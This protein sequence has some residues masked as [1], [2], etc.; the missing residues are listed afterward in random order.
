MHKVGRRDTS[1]QA[2]FSLTSLLLVE[3]DILISQ[4]V[5][6]YA[7]YLGCRIEVADTQDA[8]KRAITGEQ[9]DIV[10]LDIHLGDS[11]GLSLVPIFKQLQVRAK[12][13][14]V[15]GDTSKERILE[16]L[17]CGAN[18]FLSKPIT[19][20]SLN[21]CLL[22][23]S[24]NFAQAGTD[25][26]DRLDVTERFKGISVAAS[27]VRQLIKQYGKSEYPVL[28]TG[29]S[30]TGKEIVARLLHDSGMRRRSD[31]VVVDCGALADEL[32]EAELF[33]CE[34][35]AFTGAVERLGL[36]TA[37]DGGTIF[38]DEIGELPLRLQPKLLRV[39][40]EKE[41]RPLGSNRSKK[42]D[43][44]IIAATNRDLEQEVRLNRFRLDLFYRL[45]VLQIK[46]P[47][48]RTRRE[49]IVVMARH[50]AMLEHAAFSTP[51]K[52]DTKNALEGYDWPGNARELQN[53][54]KRARM[55]SNGS[56]VLD[57][58]VLHC[59][60]SHVAQPQQAHEPIQKSPT[61]LA[62]IEKQAIL[63]TLKRLQGNRDAAALLLG[64]SKS[65]LYRKLQEYRFASNV[66]KEVPDGKY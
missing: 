29:E 16:S 9:F 7:T 18:D 40:Q 58:A 5:T 42:I 59:I 33:G 4:L 12:V 63:T 8:A 2:L 52:V 65:T 28:I 10:L 55:V 50:F 34:K 62:E 14:V 22:R 66:T 39:L 19:L 46:V 61:S 60:S 11:N 51:L 43:V 41:V 49:D 30:G 54:V 64:I 13:V 47:P 31:F 37:A 27:N 44:R 45:N 3:D 38:L 48:L 36:L 57:D 21:E 25:G 6:E 1:G 20:A 56:S 15:T 17:R 53:L 24:N 32:M 35:G 23:V 26:P